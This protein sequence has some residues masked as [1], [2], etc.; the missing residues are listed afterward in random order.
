MIKQLNK[1]WI[2]QFFFTCFLFGCSGNGIYYNDKEKAI[3][4]CSKK[5]IKRMIIENKTKKYSFTLI[6]STSYNNNFFLLKPNKDY[7]VEYRGC[8]ENDFILE[9]NTRY[10]ITNRSNGDAGPSVIIIDVDSLYNIT[11]VKQ[12]KCQ[13]RLFFPF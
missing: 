7:E 3:C 6:H 13:S 11:D 12:T 9:P 1:N 2:I 8:R 5:N 10:L 4:S